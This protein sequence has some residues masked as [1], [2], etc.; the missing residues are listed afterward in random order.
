MLFAE[1]ILKKKPIRIF[2]HGKMQRDFTYID[3]IVE[4]IIRVL[5]KPA[6]PEESFDNNNPDPAISWAPHRVFNIGNSNPIALM[7]FITCLETALG[8]TAIKH[9]AANATW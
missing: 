8:C 3:D 7:D 5:K 1:A 6:T 9:F 2:N 4:G